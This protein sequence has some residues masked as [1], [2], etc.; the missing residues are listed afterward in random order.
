MTCDVENPIQANSE[1]S[2]EQKKFLKNYMNYLCYYENNEVKKIDSSYF[3]GKY[4]G[5]FFGASWCKYC[6][7]FIDNLNSFKKNFPFIEIIYIPFDQTYKDYLNFLRNMHFYSLPFDN[8]L[9]IC[10]KFQIKNLPAF[11]VIAPNNSILVKDAVQLIRTDAYINNFKSLIKNYI[12]QPSTFKHNNRFFD[13][14]SS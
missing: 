14:F 10:K 7:T 1:S 4:L 3:H 13:L 6:V 5:L 11:M 2:I 12:I 8:Y 9:F